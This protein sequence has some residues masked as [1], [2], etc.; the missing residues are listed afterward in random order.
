MAQSD[1]RPALA[2]WFGT[3]IPFEHCCVYWAGIVMARAA[4]A[5]AS[6]FVADASDAPVISSEIAITAIIASS[7]MAVAALIA[8]LGI[9]LILPARRLD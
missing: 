2:A 6:A 3:A 4:G 9:C 7:A 5:D 8:Y 1:T